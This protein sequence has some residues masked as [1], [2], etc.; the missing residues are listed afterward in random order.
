MVH[1]LVLRLL[2]TFFASICCKPSF[3]LNLDHVDPGDT[4]VFHLYLLLLKLT[5]DVSG[6]NHAAEGEN[7]Q[8]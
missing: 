4:G 3:S 6:C 2:Q 1:G 7:R 5:L 8:Q